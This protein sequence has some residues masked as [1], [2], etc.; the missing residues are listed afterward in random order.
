[1]QAL[2]QLGHKLFHWQVVFRGIILTTCC[3]DEPLHMLWIRNLYLMTSYFQDGSIHFIVSQ[4]R[5]CNYRFI[6]QKSSEFFHCALTEW[7]M[8]EGWAPWKLDADAVCKSLEVDPKSGIPQAQIEDRQRKYGKNETPEPPKTPYWKLLISQFEDNLVRI[9]LAAA[10][11][12]FVLAFFEEGEESLTAFVEPFVILTILIANAVVG[13]WQESNAEAAIQALRSF[14]SPTAVVLRDGDLKTIN[15]KEVVPGD[16]CQVHV[17]DQIPADI[18]VLHL[19]STTIRIDQS[20]LTGES[21]TIMKFPDVVTDD[22]ERW[23]TN[24]LFAGT[25]VAYGKATGVVVRT[26]VHTEYGKLEKQMQEGEEPDTPLKKKLD[27]FGELLTKVITVI[28]IL[29]WVVNIRH[30]TDNEHGSFIRGAIYYFKIAVALAVAAIPEGLPAVVKTCLALG[31]R[32]MAKKNALIRSLPSVETLG[33]TTVICSDKT[34][35]LTTNMMSVSKVCFFGADQTLHEADVEETRLNIKENAIRLDNKPLTHPIEKDKGFHDVARVCALCNDASLEFD[36]KTNSVTKVGEATEA[37]LRVLVEK[38]G[39]P[40]KQAHQALTLLPPKERTLHCNRY[41]EGQYE[42]KATLEFTRDRKSMSSFCEHKADN[43][44]WLFVKGAPENILARSTHIKLGGD[45]IVP[46]T[47]AHRE[48]LSTKLKELGSGRQTLRCLGLAVKEG[49]PPLHSI[50]LT[51][52]AKFVD[53]EADL[54]FVGMVGMSDPPRPEVRD[55]IT[56][57]HT[58]GIRVIV[59]TGDNKDTA[60]AICRRIGVF[61][62][63][64]DLKGKSFTGYEWDNLSPAQRLE[65]VKHARLFSR[66][67]PSHKQSLVKALQENGEVVAMTGDGVNDAP[68]L[69]SADIGVAMGTGTEV[70]KAASKMVLSDD[71]FSTIVAAVEEG[72]AI[73]ANTKQFIRY[74]I[75]SNIGE[76]VCIFLTAMLGLPETL[77]PVQLLWVNLVT[78]G[79]PATALGFNP[80]DPAIMRCKPRKHTEP[81][82]NGWLFCRYLVIGAY[83]GLATI[84]GFLWWYMWYEQGPHVSFYQLTHW[85]KCTPQW[86]V[87]GGC[88][89]FHHNAPPTMSL[90]V[91]VTVEM[92]NALNAL[93]ED[94]SLLRIGPASNRWLLLAI[95]LSFTLHF[96]V[97]YTEVM[98]SIFGLTA[99]SLTEWNAVLA[100]SAPVVFVDEILK[101]L[102][103]IF[104]K[105]QREHEKEE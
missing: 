92:F 23:P 73:Y 13:I 54:V 1:M 93:S 103:R 31:T 29:V 41:W 90:S 66:T 69:K 37:A 39:L 35:T 18:R 34:G 89:I 64:E 11:I 104:A 53:I 51:T 78:D 67:D 55:S 6:L 83:V 49:L 33:C 44:N 63:H 20:L 70:A 46:I 48:V 45:K 105:R 14:V 43:K 2:L 65:A 38:I 86:G 95:L 4:T 91:L 30:F 17:G 26:G 98:R 96:L 10:V 12:S 22:K 102:S 58:A 57:C 61:D 21:V 94:E 82:V 81:I 79:L 72:R 9:L 100:I 87:E 56:K 88:K 97:L 42:K 32:K 24:M 15:A 7:L 47:A 75:S 59:I 28:C 80:P 3:I 84:G 85:N 71:N 101:F 8:E 62:D 52:P 5:R 68:A 77:V 27:E 76:V 25:S 50:D 40:S 16:I 74:L 36:T 99:L 19:I 60:E